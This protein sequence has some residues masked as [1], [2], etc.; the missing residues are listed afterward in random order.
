MKKI[1]CAISP[2]ATHHIHPTRSIEQAGPGPGSDPSCA[3]HTVHVY[4]YINI[5][6]HRNIAP[7]L[8]LRF[9]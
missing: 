2:P 7:S 1:K 3:R 9:Y 8:C 5:Y 6:T 4:S